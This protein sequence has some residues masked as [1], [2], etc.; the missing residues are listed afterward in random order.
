MK[1]DKKIDIKTTKNNES[2]YIRLLIFEIW[3]K[4]NLTEKKSPVDDINALI[5]PRKI[6]FKINGLLIKLFFAPTR[7]MVWITNL[8]L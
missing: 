6:Y 3:F 5:K 7:N 2:P 1:I 4:K 8:L